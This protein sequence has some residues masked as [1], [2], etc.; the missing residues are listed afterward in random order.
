MM[1]IGLSALLMLHTMP[2]ARLHAAPRAEMRIANLRCEYLPNP[3]AIETPRPRLY[4][5]LESKQR[6]QMQSAYQILVASAPE[7]LKADRGDLWDSGKVVSDQSIHVAYNGKPLH[8]GQAAW[9]KVRTWDKQGRASAFSSPAHWE[10]GM[11]SPSDWKAQWIGMPAPAA[12]NNANIWQNAKWIWYPEGNPRQSAPAGTRYFLHTIPVRADVEMTQAELIG[13]ADNSFEVRVNGKQVGA[14]SGWQS[15]ARINIKD[16]LKPGMST[17]WLVANNTDGPAGVAAALSI[18]YADGSVSRVVTNKDWLAANDTPKVGRFV[19]GDSAPPALP[20]AMEIANIG[21]AP[22]GMPG[23]AAAD[24]PAPYLRKTFAIRKPIRSARVYATA[25]GLYK[26]SFN[27]KPVSQDIFRP[28]WTDYNKRIQYQTYDVTNLLQTGQNA[29]GVVLGDGWFCGHV[30]LT[31]GN[32]YGTQPRAFVQLHLTYQDGM[33]ETVVSDASWKAASGPILRDDLLDGETYDAR[34][35]MPGWNTAEFDDRAWQTAEASRSVGAQFIAPDAQPQTPNAQRPTPLLVSQPDQSVEKVEELKARSVAEKPS[36]AYVFD[37]GQNMVGW[38]RIKVKAEAGTVVRIR[39]A[40]MLSPDGTVYTTNLRGAKATDY[41]TCKGGG[42]E[43]WEPSFT[44]HGFRYVELTGLASKP[45]LDAV[46]G[47]VITSATPSAGTFACSSPLVNQLQHN[48]V[49]GQRGNYLEVPTDCPQRDERL[50]W[51]GDAQIFV[52]TAAYNSD[53]AAFMTKWTQDVVDAQSPEGGFSDVTPRMGDKADG[54]PAWGDAGII[55]PWT[56][57]RCYGDTRLVAERYPAMQ[58]WV[59]YIRSANPDFI[60]RKRANNNFGDWLNV[61][62]DTPREIL[63]TA[64]FAYDAR[65]MAEMARAI[66][67][68]EDAKQ[69]EDLFVNIKAA[70]NREFVG[71]DGR[72]KSDTQTAYVLAL[73]FSLLPEAKRDVAARYLVDDIV[74][75]R[76]GHLSTGF[77]GVGYLTPTLT[78]TG[79]LDVAYRLLNND[80]YPSWGYSIR[81]GAT[82][83]W[84]RWD[85]W[86]ETKG[87]QDPGMNSFNHYSLGSV[88]EWMYASVAGI[89]LDPNQP[90]YKHSI[91]HP[92]PGGGLT[93]AR[94]TY[95]SIH[96][97]IVSDWKLEN[98]QFVYHVTVPA[99]TTATVY[100]PTQSG[101]QVTEG[102]KPANKAEGVTFARMENGCA[103]YE[104]GSGAYTFTAPQPSSSLAQR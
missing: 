48:I 86:T 84:E 64:Y 17:I 45:S 82:T 41:Y 70:F 68:A 50:G 97:R 7:E 55:V 30:G 27:G 90:A 69:Y 12:A 77:L 76:K 46:T 4:W 24:R 18:T 85:G 59:E 65:L 58:K 67:K 43:T 51:M 47:V 49:W 28:G 42:V 5:T 16:A 98:G 104:V 83:I 33:T 37:M 8:S 22:W 78:Q 14:Q 32:N 13:I 26:L 19:T 40:E 31:G 73:R 103:V 74:N 99:N 81:Q 92:H 34:K 25:Q 75:K 87:F 60:W 52:R 63:A 11:L 36:R 95:D 102:G 38:A 2:A 79:H 57:Y 61:Q 9:W 101:E 53:I 35:E 100:V 44:F 62:S 71:A 1:L 21:D 72:I 56:I 23:G 89:D 93:Y 54:A 6:G 66:G 29:V 10:M 94:A 20:Y 15:P 91:L 3:L 80:T 96:G 88:G 39:F